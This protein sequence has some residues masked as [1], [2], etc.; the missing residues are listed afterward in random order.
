MNK[1]NTHSFSSSMRVSSLDVLI[2]ISILFLALSATS[3]YAATDTATTHIKVDQVGYLPTAP[4]I[5]VVDSSGTAQSFTVKRTDDNEVVFQGKLSP[6]VHDLSSGDQV[7]AAD[8][9]AFRKAGRY[10]IDVP[11][12]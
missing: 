6:A 7:Q 11:G 2:Q 1:E 5:A 12:V 4:K 9:S 3:A 10:Y 8:F